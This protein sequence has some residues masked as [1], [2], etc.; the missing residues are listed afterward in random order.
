MATCEI[1]KR[2]LIWA[3]PHSVLVPTDKTQPRATRW[4]TFAYQ[5]RLDQ[6][7]SFLG[8]LFSAIL[9]GSWWFQPKPRLRFSRV[10][11]KK[12]AARSWYG[13]RSK[14]EAVRSKRLK[15]TES[16]REKMGT[17]I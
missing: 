4:S 7:A 8:I 1:R 2:F 9:M 16:C 11:S 17:P 12:P 15:S 3:F 14:K 13:K 5:L 6:S 10:R